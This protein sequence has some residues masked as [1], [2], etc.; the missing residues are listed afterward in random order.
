MKTKLFTYS[1]LCLA[2]LGAGQCWANDP[3]DDEPLQLEISM[4][5]EWLALDDA[6]LDTLR[7]GF[8]MGNGL[9]VS[10]GFMRSIAI[11]G[12]QVSRTSFHF[13]DLQNITPDQARVASEA[14]AQAGVVQVGRNNVVSPADAA[15]NALS[16]VSIVQNSLNNQHISALT[17]I[18]TTVNSMGLIKSMNAR[19]SMQEA[20]LGSLNVR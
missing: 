5:A 20:L 6:M 9:K 15:Q 2:A 18:N 14:M 1:A 7:G 19:S 8:D 3:I 11:N 13:T 4:P 10:F 17:E 12:E 16:A